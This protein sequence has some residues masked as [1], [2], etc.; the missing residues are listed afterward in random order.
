MAIDLKIA[1]ATPDHSGRK[2]KC[3]ICPN[4]ETGSRKLAFFGY[5]PEKEFDSYYCGC[6][7][8]S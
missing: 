3:D 7:G 1:P 6:K 5:R 2:A 4:M 8:W